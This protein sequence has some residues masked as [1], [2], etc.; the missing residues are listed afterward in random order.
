MVLLLK[1]DIMIIV[2]YFSLI[3]NLKRNHFHLD[4]LNIFAFLFNK[5]DRGKLL[6]DK[7]IKWL[8]G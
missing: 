1:N 2:L 5:L 4:S 3:F 8:T 7:N 6:Y